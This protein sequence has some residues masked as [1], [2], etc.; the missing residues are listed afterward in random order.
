[1]RGKP[2]R[3]VRLVDKGN[4]AT[5]GRAHAVAETR[6]SRSAACSPWLIWLTVHVFYLIGPR[7]D[8]RLT[9]WAFSFVT[10]GRGARLITGDAA[11]T[12]Q[13]LPLD[14]DGSARRDF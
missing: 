1:V 4:L 11:T 9:R 5:V 12:A 2:S 7:T 8:P 14:V 13:E 10:R 6:G 3:P